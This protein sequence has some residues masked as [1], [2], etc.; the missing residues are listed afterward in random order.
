MEKTKLLE[1]KINYQL[2]LKEDLI[3]QSLFMILINM[4]FAVAVALLFTLCTTQLPNLKLYLF[5][6]LSVDYA[7]IFASTTILF[8]V[9]LRKNIELNTDEDINEDALHNLN[10]RLKKINK[11]KKILIM[12]SIII[13]FVSLGVTLAGSMFSMFFMI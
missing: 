7:C 9:A 2:N 8:L 4:V 3:K 5:I 1:E 10:E 11:T 13:S 12:T 6:F